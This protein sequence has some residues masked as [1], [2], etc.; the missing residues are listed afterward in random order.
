MSSA[1][2]QSMTGAQH[3]HADFERCDSRA[4]NLHKYFDPAIIE[5]R[6]GALAPEVAQHEQTSTQNHVR[7]CRRRRCCLCARAAG[8]CWRRTW[9]WTASPCRPPSSTLRSFSST[10]RGSCS[11]AARAPTSTC[12]RCR[13]AEEFRA[14]VRRLNPDLSRQEACASAAVLPRPMELL[15]WSC[16][17]GAKCSKPG[18]KPLAR[19]LW[20]QFHIDR[21]DSMPAAGSAC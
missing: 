18:S 17:V 15:T 12:P 20:F 11:R 7:L 4:R 5:S 8:T 6:H 3:S 2:R 14:G 19:A 9:P 10:T 13:W 1:R 21:L 16:G